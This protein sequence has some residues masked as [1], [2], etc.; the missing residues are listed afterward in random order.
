MND[1]QTGKMLVIYQSGGLGDFVKTWGFLR[2]NPD[3]IIVT[4]KD[5]GDLLHH[6][7]GHTFLSDDPWQSFFKGKSC[8]PP[9]VSAFT[10]IVVYRH[11]YFAKVDEQ[12]RSGLK[13]LNPKVNVDLRS[14]CPVC[15]EGT[16]PDPITNESGR[17]IFHVGAGMLEFSK[18]RTADYLKRGVFPIKAWDL[19]QSF[20]FARLME[21][22]GD[23]VDL[24]AGPDQRNQWVPEMLQTFNKAH[25]SFKE[26]GLIE[27]KDLISDS[28]C[29]IG[30]DSGPTHLAAQL[31]VPTVGMYGPTGRNGVDLSLHD[32]YHA[33][34]LGPRVH[35]CLIHPDISTPNSA[36]PRMQWLNPE[37]A[38]D[39]VKAFLVRI[40]AHR[41]NHG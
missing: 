30:F 24:I 39:R 28:K 38:A 12:I 14:F 17:I 23:L 15:C 21:K 4:K 26:R 20:E 27:L 7:L 8:P 34:P 19:G 29:F 2:N 41:S 35:L 16:N 25:G 1:D 6:T 11:E 10:N 22:G 9:L 31:G 32:L 37:K 40:Y 36:K 5:Q 33:E 18:A 13:S 3:A